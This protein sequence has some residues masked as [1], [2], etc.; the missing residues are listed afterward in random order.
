RAPGSYLYRADPDQG[1]REAQPG[2]PRERR[3]DREPPAGER[4]AFFHAQQPHAPAARRTQPRGRDVESPTVVT[5]FQTQF[6]LCAGE[7]NP[8]FARLRVARNIGERLLR[9]A[10]ARSFDLGGETEGHPLVCEIRL[11]SGA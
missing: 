1:E 6:L 3:V 2:L 8:N 11:E 7:R 4:R 5:H 9:D 10:K